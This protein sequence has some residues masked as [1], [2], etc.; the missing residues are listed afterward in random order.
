MDFVIRILDFL[1][2]FFPSLEDAAEF[3][4]NGRYYAA[5][6][7]TSSVVVRVGGLNLLAYEDCIR[8]ELKTMEGEWFIPP[9]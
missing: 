6:I 9:P 3:G 5:E 2:K 1:V 7:V 8:I 4:K